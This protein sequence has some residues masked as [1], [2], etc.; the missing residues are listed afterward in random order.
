MEA[1][2]KRL[3]VKYNGAPRRERPFGIDERSWAIF[4]A[5]VY[6]E[7][8]LQDLR[9]REQV[10]LQRLRQIL[11]AV[12]AQLDLRSSPGNITPQSALEDLGLSIRARNALHRLGCRSVNDLLQLDMSG[13]VARLGEKTRVE[14]LVALQSAGFRHPALDRGP[15]VGVSGLA[16]RL[17]RMQE[18]INVA[19]RSVAKEVSVVQRQLQ[20]WLKE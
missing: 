14:V 11:Y 12:D 1:G 15:M 7:Q 8:S 16:R 4:T 20:E 18:R 5:Y 3:R 6:Q 13:V 10:S 17:D 19:L 9:K 2:L